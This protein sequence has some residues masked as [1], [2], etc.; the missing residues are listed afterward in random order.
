MGEAL[1]QF[2][3]AII[4]RTFIDGSGTVILSLYSN[5]LVGSTQAPEP[6]F[7]KIF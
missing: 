7:S 1:P 6:L 4:A 2:L 5:L 3:I